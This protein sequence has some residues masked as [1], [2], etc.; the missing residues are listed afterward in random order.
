M[1]VLEQMAAA[2]DFLQ[3]ID[4]PTA[5]FQAHRPLHIEEPPGPTSRSSRSRWFPATRGSP[6]RSSSRPPWRRGSRDDR[7]SGL[8]QPDPRTRPDGAHLRQGLQQEAARARRRD[9]RGRRASLAQLHDAGRQFRFGRVRPRQRPG[10]RAAFQRQLSGHELCGA[11]RHGE[12]A[13]R[14]RPRRPA[15]A[16]DQNRAPRT[17]QPVI[18]AGRPARES[19]RAPRRRQPDHPADS[20]HFAGRPARLAAPGDTGPL[21]RRQASRE[22][23]E[24]TEAVASDYRD[25]RG[26]PPHSSA[27]GSRSICRRSSATPT[28]CSISRS[29]A[30]GDRAALRAFFGHHEPQPPH[31]L[32][33]RVQHRRQQSRKSARSRGNGIRAFPRR[34]RS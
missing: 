23:I 30:S 18:Q 21:L 11:R 13:A 12:E 16:A 22:F 25:R 3:E 17:A 14:R 34:S 19:G 26:Y 31:V 20:E 4:N 29:T 33:E 32:P 2:V 5:R 6:G 7:L 9:A 8:R 28:M 27:S 10:P 24:E 15:D 1:G